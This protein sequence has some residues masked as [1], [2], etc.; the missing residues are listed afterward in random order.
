MGYKDTNLYTY[1]Y[2]YIPDPYDTQTRNRFTICLQTSQFLCIQI[3]YVLFVIHERKYVIR[4]VDLEFEYFYQSLWRHLYFFNNFFRKF[5][6]NDSTLKIP[7]LVSI[8]LSFSFF[9]LFPL[10]GIIKRRRQTKLTHPQN[11]NN[12][13]T[14]HEHSKYYIKKIIH[15]FLKFFDCTSLKV[16]WT[17]TCSPSLR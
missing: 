6:L 12:T 15:I 4:N 13:Y 14:L 5:T 9:F 17:W 8:S 10:E 16:T 7:T 1:I 2:I 11:S 3:K